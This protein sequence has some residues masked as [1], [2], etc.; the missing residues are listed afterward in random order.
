MTNNRIFIGQFLPQQLMVKYNLS[1]AANNFCY[2][3][4]ALNSFDSCLSVPPL[5]VVDKIHFYSDDKTIMYYTYRLF[6]HK[7][8]FKYVNSLIENISCYFKMLGSR[9]NVIWFYNIYKGN[10][11]LA[12]LLLYF[13]RKRVY[14]LLADYNPSRASGV[15]QKLIVN[16]LKK[17]KGIISLSARCSEINKNF[18][19]IPGILM[20][21]KLAKQPRP[22][23]NTKRFLLSG[24]LNENTGLYMAIDVFKKIPDYTLVLSG[25]LSDDEKKE[26]QNLI[27]DYPNIILSGYLKD[28]ND[29]L[30]LL[31]S[32]DF[33][34]SLRDENKAVNKYNFP[35]KILEA[36]SMNIPVLSTMVYPE[37]KDIPYF[38]SDYDVDSIVAKIMD[39]YTPQMQKMVLKASDNYEKL[40]RYYTQEAWDKAFYI[41]ENTK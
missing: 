21:N 31:K 3:I 6:P 5:N 25:S 1:Q 12:Y 27:K 37:L 10:V 15:M 28:Y 33:V 35:S 40:S 39:L 7:R 8:V 13:S 22:F 14:V 26:V 4:M 2:K 29:Y 9:K 36:L 20:D 38:T 32:V 16:A 19:S 30:K 17:S 18:M 41:S 11:L 24:T 34:L 23:S